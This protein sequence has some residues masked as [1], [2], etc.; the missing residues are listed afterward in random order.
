MLSRVTAGDVLERVVQAL[1]DMR[2]AEQVLAV[3]LTEARRMLDAQGA[4]VLWL[5]GDRLVPRASA[6]LLPPGRDAGL[7]RGGGIEGWVVERGEAIAVANPARYLPVASPE[8]G[9]VGSLLAVPMRLRGE[10]VGVLVATREAPGRFA[11]SDRWWLSIFAEI[12]A[13][14]LENDRLLDR[15]RRRAREAEVLAELAT[16]PTEPLEEFAA[17]LADGVGRLLGVER[18]G[19]LLADDGAGL[20]PLA[21]HV[22]LP[23]RPPSLR[24]KEESADGAGGVHRRADSAVSRVKD[25]GEATR[26]RGAHVRAAQPDAAG[27]LAEVYRTGTSLLCNETR[28]LPALVAELGTASLRSVLAVSLF[29]DGARR[30]VLWTGSGR[31]G[32]F[33]SE[34]Q[35]FL[36]LVAA[37]VGLRL[38]NAELAQR[39]AE[40]ARAEVEQQAKQ[41]FL[42]VV[43]HELKTP[44]A[45]IKAYTEVLEGRAAR[46]GAAAA[47]KD[48]LVRIGEQADRML[49]LVEQFLDLQRIEAG[50]MPLEPSRFDLAELARRLAQA[51]QVTTTAHQLRVEAP[52]PVYVR[53]DHRRIEQ[54]LQNL[55]DNAIK[56]SPDGG[57][58]VVRV[59][60]GP[61]TPLAPVP[62]REGGTDRSSSEPPAKGSGRQ[63]NAESVQ[64][65]AAKDE[66]A[67]VRVTDRGVG[68]SAGAAE[69]VFERF[70]Q[71]GTAPVRGHVGLG[72][73]LYISREIVTRHSG[74][75]GVQSA[76]SQGS[77]FWF[78]LPLAR[79]PDGDEEDGD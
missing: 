72:L 51:T 32:A 78:T 73:G 23:S 70:Y 17:R 16:I 26:G 21:G 5:V 15:E 22:D 41:D 2:S 11:E 7:P 58:I 68:I 28:E 30:G 43:S 20:R 12:A 54:V 44:V 39:R 74:Q 8:L 6:G 4:Y 69:H 61:T 3:V 1:A 19:V 64:A 27:P 47:D 62:L 76:E 53:A 66:V 75:M 33:T 56:Y 57:P 63:D 37:R 49:G 52:R 50:L 29:V 31:P 25:S 77:T 46:A 67:V 13:V 42:S 45:V 79:A 38:G 9:Q 34:D 55:L 10:V 59:D 71:A 18:T 48:V 24:G 65:A 35:T 40:V 36:G 60:A 14:A